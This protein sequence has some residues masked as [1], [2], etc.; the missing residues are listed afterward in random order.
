MK[1]YGIEVPECVLRA[2][3]AAM[4]GHFVAY[5]VESAIRA[6]GCNG[7]AVPSRVADKLLQRER[8]AGRIKFA[9][10]K[11]FRTEGTSNG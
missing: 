6:A 10:G 7:L 11:W 5:D 1:S 4:Q 9:N 3:V 8:R 2:G